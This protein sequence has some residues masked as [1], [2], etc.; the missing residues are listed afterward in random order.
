MSKCEK[1]KKESF[2][3]KTEEKKKKIRLHLCTYLQV[4]PTCTLQSVVQTPLYR[5]FK[6]FLNLQKDTVWAPLPAQ[7][8]PH[9][10]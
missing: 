9:I 4:L 2:T 3:R 10:L 8:P 1:R 7:A 6:L 5:K